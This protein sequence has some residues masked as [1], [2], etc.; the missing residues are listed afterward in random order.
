MTGTLSDNNTS[1]NNT[2]ITLFQACLY[3]YNYS[4]ESS[5]QIYKLVASAAAW[6]NAKSR[7]LREI[8]LHKMG[9][10]HLGGYVLPNDKGLV[11]LNAELLAK[12]KVPEDGLAQ[13]DERFAYFKEL[14]K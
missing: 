14:C 7:L 8:G 2:R 11:W 6:H 4:A 9:I 13:F 12:D 10:T 3:L 5:E 1:A